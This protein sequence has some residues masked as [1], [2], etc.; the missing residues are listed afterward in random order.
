MLHVEVFLNSENCLGSRK[1]VRHVEVSVKG[2]FTVYIYIYIIS[3]M[4]DNTYLILMNIMTTTTRGNASS[5]LSGR[6]RACIK[7]GGVCRSNGRAPHCCRAGR[8]A[9]AVVPADFPWRSLTAVR[10]CRVGRDNA[11]LPY[12]DKMTRDS[13]TRRRLCTPYTVRR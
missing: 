10:F 6:F 12:G 1:D 8:S 13:V 5:G 11:P 9:V 3:L 4:R 7:P 2:D